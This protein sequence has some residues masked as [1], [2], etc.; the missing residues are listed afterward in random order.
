M[1]GDRRAP[2]LPDVPTFAEAGYPKVHLGLW[3]ALLGP[4]GMPPA[5]VAYLSR[6]LQAALQSPE[7]RKRLGDLGIE[8]LDGRPDTLAQTMA[9][10]EP[11]YRKVVL[12]AGI[13]VD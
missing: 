11:V 5:Q 8:P 9:R 12:D 3:C 4:A 10:E 7:L 13:K 2:E 6:E 1:S